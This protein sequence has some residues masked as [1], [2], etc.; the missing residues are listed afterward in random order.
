MTRTDIIGELR[1]LMAENLELDVPES[2]E[3]SARLFEDLAIDSIMVLQLVV[4]IEEQFDVSF[5]E[6][7]LDPG[8]FMTVGSLTDLIE[9]LLPSAV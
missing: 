8:A 9:S 1:T 2:L 6:E 4:Y 3:E 5:P 7:S